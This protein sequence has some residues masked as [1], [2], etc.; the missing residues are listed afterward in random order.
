MLDRFARVR[1]AGAREHEPICAAPAID[2]LGILW[3]EPKD[4]LLHMLDVGP[5]VHISG[6]LL[7]A[8]RVGGSRAIASYGDG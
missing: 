5:A 8:L 4:Q 6:S 2:E 1:A 3:G 7:V